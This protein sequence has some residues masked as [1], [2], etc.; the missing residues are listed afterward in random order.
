LSSAF[1]PANHSELLIRGRTFL[2]RSADDTNRRAQH[3]K[4]NMAEKKR[5]RNEEGAERPSKKTAVAPQGNVKVELL[6]EEAL[7]P[8]LGMSHG[9]LYRRQR[10]TKTQLRH[11]ALSFPRVSTSSRT[12]TPTSSPSPPSP[13]FSS[14]LQTTPASTT[15]HSKSRMAAQ[16]V[17]SRT[18]WACL[19][20]RP[21][22]CRLCQS[23]G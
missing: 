13:H 17:K 18:T 2:K 7:G 21:R 23:R 3:T 20:Q 11:Q 4:H 1:A 15:P 14:S 12:S 10:L 6:Q 19:T 8:L 22:S 5:K 16:G 9:A